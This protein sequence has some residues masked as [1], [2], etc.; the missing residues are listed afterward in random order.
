MLLQRI[1]CLPRS[2]HHAHDLDHQTRPVREMRAGAG[3]HVVILLP[4]ESRLFP[5]PEDVLDQILPQRYIQS[6]VI[7]SDP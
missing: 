4:R 3:P 5:L 6:W 1:M 7:L 2:I